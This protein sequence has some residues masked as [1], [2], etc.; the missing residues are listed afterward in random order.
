MKCKKC[1][2]EINAENYYVRLGYECSNC[3]TQCYSSSLWEH[4]FKCGFKLTPKKI[5]KWEN[6]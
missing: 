1:C 5:K 4:D 2:K 3:N 6:L